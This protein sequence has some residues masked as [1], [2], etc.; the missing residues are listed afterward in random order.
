VRTRSLEPH[1]GLIRREQVARPTRDL[2][3]EPR[4]EFPR[5]E[6]RGVA[7]R[8]PDDGEAAE[9]DDDAEEPARHAVDD[10]LDGD[11]GGAGRVELFV[12]RL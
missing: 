11:L 7:P 2:L 3:P 4:V 1:G 10:G 8:K 6:L 5:H 12:R 9:G